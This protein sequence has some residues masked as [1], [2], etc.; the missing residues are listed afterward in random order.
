MKKILIA[1][2]CMDMVQADF[3]HSLA[4]LT[5]MGVEGYN[6]LLTMQKGSLIYE[7]RNELAKKSVQLGCDYTLWL[8][9]DMV[10]P[11][12]ALSKMIKHMENGKQFVTGVYY[13]RVKPYTPV[14]FK[15]LDMHQKTAK[16]ED[17]NDYPQDKPFKIGG[18][19]FGCVLI[20]N[21]IL[22][23]IAGKNEQWFSPFNNLGEDLAFCQ[24]ARDCGYDIWCD[25]TIQCGHTGSLVVTKELYDSLRGGENESKDN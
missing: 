16:W 6:F 2:P 9:S 14:L 11:A 12:D 8:D 7:S 24:R 1:V 20:D 17:Y 13:R 5:S 21:E 10:V 15:E 4:V 23:S 19:G 25:P 18:C 22:F 3:A